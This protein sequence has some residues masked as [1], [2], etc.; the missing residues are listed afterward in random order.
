MLN[1]SEEIEN[2]E[3]LKDKSSLVWLLPIINMLLLVHKSIL[4]TKQNVYPTTTTNII[5]L[6]KIFYV[7]TCAKQWFF[8]ARILIARQQL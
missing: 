7:S 2:T 6:Q 5:T 1:S 4:P 8:L 3:V